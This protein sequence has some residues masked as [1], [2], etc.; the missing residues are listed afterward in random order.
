[1]HKDK[2]SPNSLSSVNQQI[3][4]ILKYQDIILLYTRISDLHIRYKKYKYKN[5]S[6]LTKL[7]LSMTERIRFYHQTDP[8]CSLWFHYYKELNNIIF[9]LI[10]VSSYQDKLDYCVTLLTTSIGYLSSSDS[11]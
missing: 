2:E 9:T 8:T 6:S 3:E 5:K 7:V 1:M 11:I 4:K 10:N